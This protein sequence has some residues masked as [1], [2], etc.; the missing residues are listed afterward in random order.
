MP[1][2]GWLVPNRI[3]IDEAG[4][5]LIWWPGSHPIEDDQGVATDFARIAGGSNEAILAYAR[6][7]GVLELC[8]HGLPR[9][10][11]Q[12]TVWPGHMGMRNLSPDASCL[13]IQ[14][15]SAPHQ[16]VAGFGP[17]Q[18]PLSGWR[19]YTA[20][21]RAIVDLA[22][23]LRLGVQG[24]HEDW[25]KASGESDDDQ[26][27]GSPWDLARAVEELLEIAN[28][29]PLFRWRGERGYEMLLGVPGSG[30]AGG[31]AFPAIAMQLALSVAR[32]DG[33]AYCSG[34]GN[35]FS[36]KESRPAKGE[37]RY[38]QACRDAKIDVRD[39]KRRSRAAAK[40]RT[41]AAPD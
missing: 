4:D 8:K 9:T 33:I 18:E 7:W 17:W 1:F 41:L 12:P 11:R 16:G 36:A 37:H 21:V 20:K 26:W 38:C 3:E 27:I 2:A 22:G 24:S 35:A 32:S 25:V 23:Q 15:E 39:R 10:H 6:K 28:I 29:R 31:G 13:P 30:L 14:H 5:R 34:C 19:T 40:A